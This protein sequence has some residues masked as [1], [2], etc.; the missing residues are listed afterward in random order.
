[1]STSTDEKVTTDLIQTLKDGQKGF[2]DAAERL[3]ES[4]RADLAPTFAE[5]SAQRAEFARE[6]ETMAAAYGDDID[7]SGSIAGAIHRGWIGLK[8]AVT[9]SSAGAIIDAA[10]TGEEH[11]VAEFEK[12][13]EEKI[14]DGLRAKVQTQFFAVRAAADDVK[15]MRTA[16]E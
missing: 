8:D 2:A 1:M 11:A 4:D 15:M 7:E 3:A 14:S 13:L 10:V 12:A 16:V 9:G 6:L 5:L